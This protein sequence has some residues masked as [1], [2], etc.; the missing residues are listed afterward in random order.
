MKHTFSECAQKRDEEPSLS[1]YG[2]E[3]DVCFLDTLTDEVPKVPKGY[4][5]GFCHFWHSYTLGIST[6]ALPGK[7]VERG[8]IQHKRDP[9]WK[10]SRA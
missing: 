7:G 3:E 8:V 4:F 10:P 1:W 5:E 2:A 6:L 9:G